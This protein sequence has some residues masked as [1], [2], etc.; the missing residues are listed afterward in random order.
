M[1]AGRPS[2]FSSA[3]AE[4]ICERIASGESLRSI[5]KAK[6]MPDVR[7]IYRWLADPARDEFRH[8][9]ARARAAQTEVWLEEIFEIADDGSHDSFTDSD[10]HERVNHDHI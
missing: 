3:I 4:T 2:E 10:G 1:P 8:Q 9:Y 5:A 6:E 7:T